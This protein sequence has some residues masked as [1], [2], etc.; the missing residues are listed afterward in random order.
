MKKEKLL[1]RVEELALGLKEIGVYE[2]EVVEDYIKESKSLEE[3]DLEN[4]VFELEEYYRVLYKDKDI[5]RKTF[6]KYNI[7]YD[8]LGVI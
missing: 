7:S 2:K 4:E 5:D 1:K 6:E 3:F 8:W